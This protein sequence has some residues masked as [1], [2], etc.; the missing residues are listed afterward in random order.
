MNSI[1]CSGSEHNCQMNLGCHSLVLDM[2]AVRDYCHIDR[3]LDTEPS[4]DRIFMLC[5]HVRDVRRATLPLRSGNEGW[6]GLSPSGDGYHVVVPVDAQIAKGVMACNWPTDGTPFGGYTGWL[7]F[8]CEPYDDEVEAGAAHE[9]CVQ[10]NCQKLLDFAATYGIA[11]ALQDEYGVDSPWLTHASNACRT[12]RKRRGCG[13]KEQE[14]TQRTVEVHVATCGVCGQR[15]QALT[16]L[17]RDPTIRLV[18]YRVCPD[19]FAQGLYVFSHGCSGS[20]EVPV[21]HFG[22]S[23]LTSKSLI[24]THACPGMCHFETS[25]DACSA[26]CEGACYRRIAAKLKSRSTC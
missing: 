26:V 25:L 19:D 24:G 7:Y 13:A 21:T 6:I 4:S 23:R 14:N 9:T 5:I 22:R 12:A 15:W 20:V 2:H 11:G 3:V 18:R 17:L 1:G 10:T 8:R 16:D